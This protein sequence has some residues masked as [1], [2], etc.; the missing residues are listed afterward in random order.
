MSII[1]PESRWAWLSRERSRTGLLESG[2]T[3]KVRQQGLFWLGLGVFALLIQLWASDPA[4]YLGHTDAAKYLTLARNAPA[5]VLFE[6]RF[7][8]LHPPVFG[9]VIRLASLG[10]LGLPTAG[11]L[12]SCLASVGLVLVTCALGRRVLGSLAGGLLAGLLLL[13]AGSTALLGQGVWREPLHTLLIY[14][15]MLFGL[16]RRAPA[17]GAAEESVEGVGEGEGLQKAAPG[18]VK[19]VAAGALGLVSGLIWDP[20]V[21]AG[22]VVLAGGILLK[23]RLLVVSAVA[24]MVTWTAWATVRYQIVR[25]DPTLPVGMDGMPEPSSADPEVG[26]RPMVFLSPNR[27][28]LTA[29]WDAY[30]WPM[31]ATPQRV[32][33]NMTPRFFFEGLEVL[34]PAPSRA[35][36]W[37]ALLVFSIVLCGA[38]VLVRGPPPPAERRELLMLAVVGVGLGLPAVAGRAPRYGYPML[39][40]LCIVAGGCGRALLPRLDVKRAALAVGV[41]LA[42]VVLAWAVVQPPTSLG[43]PK[44]TEGRGVRA[45]AQE[46]GFLDRAEVVVGTHGLTPELCWLFPDATVITLPLDGPPDLAALLAERQ[47]N[48]VVVAH[49]IHMA[50]DARVDP[51]RTRFVHGLGAIE[52]VS[53]A[54]RP[55]GVLR[56]LGVVIEAESSDC[57]RAR[58]FDV[59]WHGSGGEPRAPSAFGCFVEPAAYSTLG[60]LFARGEV[61]RETRRVLL[62]HRAPV[63]A[64]AADDADAKSVLAHLADP[65]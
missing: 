6:G 28:P 38:V 21:F 40:V 31:A 63:E 60:E 46:L 16:S 17:E 39:P 1:K 14:G 42:L 24:L 10:V 8:A 32:F 48:L 47:A 4:V 11:V 7:F 61:S 18:W 33:Y 55:G 23:R 29:Q 50:R 15:L 35:A 13:F 37:G 53:A 54:A 57:P 26:F 56:H 45:A 12:I 2:V 9:Y 52:S 30:Q 41:G 25:G 49:E 19:Q 51:G 62:Q 43:R 44:Y 3:R 36:G 59:F 65:Q 22:P 5:H 27:L 20:M 58:T 34:S 64:A